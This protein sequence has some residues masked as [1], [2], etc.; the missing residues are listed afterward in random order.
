MPA[1]TKLEYFFY[2]ERKLLPSY[3]I[4]HISL[5]IVTLPV[6]RELKLEQPAKQWTDSRPMQVGASL[7]HG[8]D[9]TQ[10]GKFHQTKKD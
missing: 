3:F 1:E 4:N 9:A 5:Q 2:N 8:K 6:Q 7:V 10:H